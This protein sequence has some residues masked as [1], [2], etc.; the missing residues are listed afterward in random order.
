MEANAP[1]TELVGGDKK[2]YLFNKWGPLLEAHTEDGQVPKIGDSHTKLMTAMVMEQ[3]EQALIQNGHLPKGGVLTET[4]DNAALFTAYGAGDPNFS[5]DPPVVG[6]YGNKVPA[7]ED[8]YARGDSRLPNVIMPMIRRVFP[9]LIANEI[10]GIQPMNA[11]VG[12]AF[13][14]RYKYEADN[15]ADFS[16][17]GSNSANAAPPGHRTAVDGQEAGYQQLPTHFTGTTALEL[18]GLGLE[19]NAATSGSDFDFVDSDIGVAELLQNLELSTAV[20]QM[21][22]S[23]EKTVVEAGTRKLAFKHSLEAQQDLF[24]MYGI[25]IEAE[26]GQ[27]MSYELQAEIDRELIIRMINICLNA[28][29]NTGY[30]YWNPASADGRW[31]KERVFN[32]WQ[33]IVAQANLVGI[34]N[35]IAPANFI[36]ATPQVVSLLETY[37]SFKSV[38]INADVQSNMGL[39][40]AGTLGGRFKVYRDTRTEAQFQAGLRNTRVDYV[41]LGYKGDQYFQTGLVYCPYIPVLLQ[42]ATGPNDFAPRYGMMTRYAIAE[43]LFGSENFY[44]LIITQGLTSPFT[45]GPQQLLT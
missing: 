37:D 8:F 10:V 17:D 11:P 26:M 43:N 14:L 39:A 18:S 21:T 31:S 2:A 13:A 7:N 25:S 1:Q 40:R 32:L 6:Q 12:M 36:V 44:H 42:K 34:R 45:A 22:M 15:L 19:S 16:P 4:V 29:P 3:Q 20:P 28:G 27:V 33:Q 35:R 41:L 9:E 5:A 24:N 30:S 38:D 23:I